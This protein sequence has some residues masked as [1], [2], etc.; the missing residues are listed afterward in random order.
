MLTFSHPHS[1]III[2]PNIMLLRIVSGSLRTFLV[3]HESMPTLS[4]PV[5]PYLWWLHWC[6]ISR[7]P[8]LVFPHSSLRPLSS[9]LAHTLIPD[10][11]LLISFAPKPPPTSHPS[12][13]RLFRLPPQP[14]VAAAHGL[15]FPSPHT[16]PTLMPSIYFTPAYTSC[17]IALPSQPWT[18]HDVPIC[19]P[20]YLPVMLVLA[21]L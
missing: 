18:P 3:F 21:I 7:M 11:V 19:F 4:Q 10:L 2:S 8:P 6:M 17:D 16:Q 5:W 1:V 13:S 15:L 20:S 9:S 12:S 14:S